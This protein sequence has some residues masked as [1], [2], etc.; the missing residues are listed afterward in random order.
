MET[1]VNLTGDSISRLFES[2]H[3][4]VALNLTTWLLYKHVKRRK[5]VLSSYSAV[6]VLKLLAQ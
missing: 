6:V 2:L 4:M 5:L 1:L 3:Q